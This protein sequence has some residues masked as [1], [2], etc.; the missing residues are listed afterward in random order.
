MK[1]VTISKKEAR[2]F[3]VSYHNLDGSQEYNGSEG[4]MNYFTKVGSIQYDPL[5]VVGRNADLVLQSKI[6]D[7]QPDMLHNLLYQDHLLIDGFDKEMCIYLAQDFPRFER[8]REAT[9]L[10]VKNTLYHRNQLE[11][12]ELLDEVWDYIT[13]HGAIGSKDISIG[14]SRE[15]RWGHKKLSSA[16]LDYLYSIGELCVANKTGTQKLYDFTRNVIPTL[17]NSKEPFATEEDFLIWYVNRRIG[18]VGLLWN[19]KGGAWQGHY[20]YDNVKRETAIQHLFEAD[21][22]IQLQVEDV[23]SP[24]YMQ[25]KDEVLLNSSNRQSQVKF[26]APLDNM[27][28]DRDMVKQLFGFEYS[29]EVYTPVVKRKYGYYVLPVIYGDQLVARFEPEKAKK[30]APF[31]IKNW[32]WEAN[33]NITEELLHTVE[34]ALIEF[35]RYLEFEYTKELIDSYSTK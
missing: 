10:A 7:Y 29:W 16:T 4:I 9:G 21:E 30:N 34:V 28:W 20:I 22:I 24:F 26:L 32:W 33:V 1:T 17:Y 23:K 6:K 12:L 35:C 13:Q 3:L 18:S 14:Q 19:K 2:Q 25:K 11:A 5:N 31:Q 8:I 27:L 15:S